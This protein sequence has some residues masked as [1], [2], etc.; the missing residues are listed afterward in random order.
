MDNSYLMK[1]AGLL[2][3]VWLLSGLHAL[4]SWLSDSKSTIKTVEKGVKY[5][6]N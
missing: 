1:P 3:Y 2:K 5:V 4:K 6:Q